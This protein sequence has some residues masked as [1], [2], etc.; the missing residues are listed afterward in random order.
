M[1]YNTFKYYLNKNY[2]EMDC[3]WKCVYDTSDLTI[4]IDFT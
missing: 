4:N 1:C 2:T 3:F